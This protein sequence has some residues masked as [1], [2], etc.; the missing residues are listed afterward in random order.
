MALQD[1][2]SMKRPLFC[3][4]MSRNRF[5]QINRDMR[6]DDKTTRD[7]RIQTG[8]DAAIYLFSDSLCERLRAIY[9][10]GPNLTVDEQLVGFFG[11]WPFRVNMPNKPDRYGI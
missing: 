6:F 8:K 7:Q 5:Q 11:R 2:A 4:T 1:D 3:A 10:P 9:N